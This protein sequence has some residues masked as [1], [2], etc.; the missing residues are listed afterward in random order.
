MSQLV[1]AMP[2]N[3]GLAAELARHLG[4]ELARGE[5]RRFPDGETLVRIDTDVKGQDLIVAARLDRPDDK[6]LALCFLAA[7]ARDLGAATIGLV[8]PY[9]P[10]MR[11]DKSFH[12]GEGVTSAYFA[13]L[14]GAHFD[15]L[16][17]VDPHLHRR[18]SLSEIY[19]IPTSVAQ[20]GPAIADWVRRNV[21]APIIVGPDGESEQWVADVARR[22]GAAY[23]VMQ[24]VRTG[25][26]AVAVSMPEGRRWDGHTAVLVDDIIST[27]RTMIAAARQLRAAGCAEIVVIGVH[28]LFAGDAFEDLVEAGIRRIATC[29]T[30]VHP[31]NEI[32]V[33]RLLAA[34]IGETARLKATNQRPLGQ[35]A[36]PTVQLMAGDVPHEPQS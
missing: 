34:A 33:S 30:V 25:D 2:G 4:A 14:L 28:A 31:S 12:P 24:K 21:A 7:T 11:Q 35:P 22:A 32:D 13:R 16:V 23:C 9:L 19:A 20:A 29:H 3:D 8:A 5:V 27:A 6:F 26:R 15:W 36:T 10:Y 17:T 1:F 18:S